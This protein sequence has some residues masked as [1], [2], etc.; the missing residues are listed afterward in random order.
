MIAPILQCTF[1]WNILF[2][3]DCLQCFFT[4]CI[5]VNESF[6]L[7]I[8]E[9]DSLVECD[10]NLLSI[11]VRLRERFLKNIYF[12]KKSMWMIKCLCHKQKMQKKRSSAFTR[13]LSV[14]L[15]FLKNTVLMSSSLQFRIVGQVPKRITQNLHLSN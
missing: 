12:L 13:L 9:E 11:T 1:A 15:I 2:K 10:C 7:E 6:C 14:L 4:S 8:Y 3:N 5:C